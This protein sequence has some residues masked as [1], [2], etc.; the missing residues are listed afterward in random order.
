M[1][2]YNPFMKGPD[3]ASGAQD[4]FTQMKMKKLMEQLVG[5]GGGGQDS[6]APM[7]AGNPF[8]SL[9]GMGQGPAMPQGSQAGG[10]MPGAGAAMGAPGGMDMSKILPLLMQILRMGGLGGTM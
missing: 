3:Y 8:T 9:V 10:G 2:F 5:M 7:M 1:P 6:Q 4:I